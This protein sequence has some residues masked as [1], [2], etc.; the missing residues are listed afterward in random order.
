MRPT[1]H[2]WRLIRFMEKAE[3]RHFRLFSQFQAG[4][5]KYEYL[6][7]A[8]KKV[9][10]GEKYDEALIKKRLDQ[11]GKVP[12]GSFAV[13]KKYLFDLL[14]KSLRLLQEDKTVEKSIRKQYEEASL[15][16][17]RGIIDKSLEYIREGKKKAEQ[18]EC[19]TILIDFLSL[20]IKH[21]LLNLKNT[22]AP[23]N[24]MAALYQEKE[25]A[26][27]KLAQE[28]EAHKLRD[29]AYLLY[30]TGNTQL[31]EP[32][33]QR[34]LRLKNQ[35][36]LQNPGKFTSFRSELYFHH[37]W[38]FIH[39]VENINPTLIFY[40][41]RKTIEVWDNYPLFK[42]EYT[43]LYK[44]NLFGYLG[45]CHSYKDYSDYEEVLNKASSLKSQNILDTIDD[46]HNIYHYRLLLLMNTGR[47]KEA[48][49]LAK[50][51]EVKIEDFT[52]RKY[53]LTKHR[54]L[55]LYYNISILL[56]VIEQYDEALKWA[57]R[58]RKEFSRSNVRTDIQYFVYIL[59]LLIQ[60]EKG[61]ADQLDYKEPYVKKLLKKNDML[62]QFDEVILNTIRKLNKS[63][64]EKE[65][66]G[67][68]KELLKNIEISEREFKKIRGREEV[69]LWARSKLS[70]IPMT[71]LL[72][73]EAEK[74]MAKI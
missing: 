21:L 27:Q 26:M 63:R 32:Q 41:Y 55:T 4:Q 1:D 68:Y 71:E 29:L 33:I 35:E 74:A 9:K 20:E 19:F 62:S 40:H 16:M 69:K 51:L 48:L 57:M 61:Q 54:L 6:Y 49:A 52:R 5:K 73:E 30:R 11:Q 13:T 58:I 53:P 37:C 10:R 59:R 14:V 70:N 64:T 67:L 34:L 28:S 17:T 60:F 22:N 44:S 50:E 23:Y 46:F 39:T 18:Y 24:R 12:A 56:F 8:V 43:Q 36:F 31:G 72:R 66:Q 15:L 2:L 45:T 47:Y 38:G 3:A 65:E 42:K 25:V 7:D